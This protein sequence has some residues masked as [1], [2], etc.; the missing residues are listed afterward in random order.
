VLSSGDGGAARSL[1]L[2]LR[3]FTEIN[4]AIPLSFASVNLEAW[5]ALDGATRAA[6]EAAGHATS[7]RSWQAMQGRVEQNYARMRDNG[8]RIDTSPAPIVLDALRAAGI[9]ARSEWESRAGAAGRAIL[10]DYL[11]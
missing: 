10:A 5:N 3:N 7:E 11:R 2:Q 6:V 4:Y 8:M 1:W 9:Q